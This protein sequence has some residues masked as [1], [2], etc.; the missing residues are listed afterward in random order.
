MRVTIEVGTPGTDE[1]GAVVA[2]LRQWQRDDAPIQLHPG[3][4]GWYWRF[5]PQATA[6]ARDLWTSINRPN[7]I[8]NILPTR[9]RASLVL[10]KD[11]DHAINRVRLRK[12]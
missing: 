1:L 7:L 6:A 12:L 9:P 3:D 4:L 8:E 5:G 11:V 2:A 10:R